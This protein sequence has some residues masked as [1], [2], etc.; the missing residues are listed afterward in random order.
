MPS[1][2]RSRLRHSHAI[3]SLRDAAQER[4]EEIFG[5]GN[6]GKGEGK[7]TG[8]SKTDADDDVVVKGKGDKDKDNDDK[9]EDKLIFTLPPTVIHDDL[10]FRKVG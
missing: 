7:V 9:E 4:A 1:P 10:L 2:S 6:G 3:A 8:E 5:K